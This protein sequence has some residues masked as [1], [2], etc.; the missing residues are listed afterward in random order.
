M[1]MTAKSATKKVAAKK[2]APAADGVTGPAES[3]AQRT[4]F[5]ALLAKHPPNAQK[6]GEAARKLILRLVP[7]VIESVWLR[8]SVASYGTG[9]KKM[10]E[11][12]AYVVFAKAHIS[13]GFNYGVD[14]PDPGGPLQ[15]SG[16]SFRSRKIHAAEDLDRPSLL[17]LLKRSTTRR[18]PPIRG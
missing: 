3:E 2:A 8:Q 12:F 15:G 9:P 7:G 17:T 11:H 6:L 10:S 4:A 16:K 1:K 5:E 14:L 18:V 13:L